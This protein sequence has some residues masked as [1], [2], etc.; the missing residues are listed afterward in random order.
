MES[1]WCFVGCGMGRPE[2]S[3]RRL[4]LDAGDERLWDGNNAVRL[5]PKAFALL[6]YFVRNPNRLLA[7]QEILDSVWPDTFVTE[8]LVREYFQDLRRALSDDPRRPRFIETVHRRGYRF[9]GGIEIAECED[10]ASGDEAIQ[11]SRLSIV[12]LR[13]ENLANDEAWERFAAG[14]CDCI[15]TDLMRF[16]NLEVVARNAVLIGKNKPIDV[17]LI[18]RDLDAAFILKSRIQAYNQQVRIIVQLLDGRTGRH[19]WADRCDRPAA[20][21]FDAQDGI[22]ESV[23]SVLG[24]RH[25]QTPKHNVYEF[26]ARSVKIRTLAD[27][28][29]SAAS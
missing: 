9:L 3:R 11:T 1:L 29:C 10:G 28:T 20:A 5:T 12:V 4:R 23:V 22:A 25:G 15:I 16:S 8:G 27:P 6:R 2:R 17:R 18:R 13:F 19:L 7:K 21:L 24:G 26:V 14:L